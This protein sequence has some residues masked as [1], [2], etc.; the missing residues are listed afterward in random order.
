MAGSAVRKR[1][2]ELRDARIIRDFMARWPAGVFHP[3]EVRRF[4]AEDFAAGRLDGHG[5][6]VVKNHML[7]PINLR[8][9][10]CDECSPPIDW[11][12]PL[13]AI[14]RATP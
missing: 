12:Q 3:N 13:F 5:V 4:I 9:V 7:G 8:T 1:R 11:S 6:Y 10:T 2:V 14:D